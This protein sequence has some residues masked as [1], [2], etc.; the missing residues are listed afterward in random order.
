MAKAPGFIFYPGDYLQDTQNLCEAAQ[1]AYDRIMCL[2][3]KYI[4]VT[5]PQL[6]FFTKRLTLEQKSELA[7]VLTQVG[8]GDEAEFQIP[9]VVDSILKYR[10]FCDSRALN[11]KGKTKK[12]VINTSNSLVP[13]VENEIESVIENEI[14][15]VLDR[16]MGKDLPIAPQMVQIFKK[17][18]PDYPIMWGSDAE[19]CMGIANKIAAM[20]GWSKESVT[21]G[22]QQDVVAEWVTLVAFAKSDSW[23]AAKSISFINDKFQDFIQA[24]KKPKQ[25]GAKGT[26]PAFRS[27]RT[28]LTNG[29]DPTEID[30]TGPGKL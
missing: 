19:A 18:F 6:E 20:K 27:N 13:L 8:E 14:D 25:D 21:N 3:M 4:C 22:H 26:P 28:G 10:S 15:T 5:K 30:R 1:V 24:L 7:M 17:E 11:R 16:G 23:Y 2:H 29:I 9:W 12:Q